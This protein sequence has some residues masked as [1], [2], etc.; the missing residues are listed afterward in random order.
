MDTRSNNLEDNI[1]DYGSDFTSD[2]DII[3]ELLSQIPPTSQESSL[4]EFEDYEITRRQGYG[5]VDFASQASPSAPAFQ[6][7]HIANKREVTVHVGPICR[8]FPK[9]KCIEKFV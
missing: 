8:S 9:L 4:N 3:N 6:Q 1:S 5:P 7:I 2:E